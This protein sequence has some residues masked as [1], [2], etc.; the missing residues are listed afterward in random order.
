MPSFFKG[1]PCK[2]DDYDRQNGRHGRMGVIRGHIFRETVGETI[3][4]LRYT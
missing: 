3:N 1:M 2:G 4:K